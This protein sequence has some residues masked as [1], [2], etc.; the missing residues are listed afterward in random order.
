MNGMGFNG[1]HQQSIFSVVSTLLHSSNVSFSVSSSDES[2]VDFDN[3]H[4][5][6]VTDLLG[7]NVDTFNDALCAI[8]IQVGKE[9]HRKIQPKHKAEKGLEA[10]IIAIYTALFRHI[11]EEINT[12]FACKKRG[13]D[14]V[15]S[16]IGVLDIFGFESFK[17]NSLEQLFINYC[18]EALQQQ[19][20]AFVFRL[21]QEVYRSE[22]K[23]RKIDISICASLY[24]LI[25][26]YATSCSNDEF[27]IFC[28]N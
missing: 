19:F 12:S 21:E 28:R 9:R 14:G 1:Q 13:K 15:A 17:T 24:F 26:A 6:Y 8:Y 16:F 4:L 7:L 11:V 25:R 27:Q 20:N 18:N 22:G 5:K 10:L 2:K 3:P 23:S